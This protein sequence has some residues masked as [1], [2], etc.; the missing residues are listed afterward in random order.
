MKNGTVEEVETAVKNAIDQGAPLENFSI[1]T[2]GLTAGVPD[3]NVRAARRAATTLGLIER[4]RFR[5]IRFK[6][7]AD[8]NIQ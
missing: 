2:V 6:A 3:D 8:H 7:H 4:T 1:D 5:P